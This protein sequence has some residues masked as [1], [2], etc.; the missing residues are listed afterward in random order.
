MLGQQCAKQTAPTGGSK[1]TIPPQLES[2][3]PKNKGINFKGTAIELTFDELVQLNN[4]REQIIITPSIG[5]KFEATVRK[6]KVTLE[7][8]SKLLEN[9]T[10]SINFR[11]SIQDLT[12]KNPAK[13]KIAFSTGSYIDSLSVTGFVTDILT[14]QRVKNYTVALVQVID[15]FNIFKHPA[16]WIGLTDDKGNFSIENL[17]PG[18][19]FLYAFNDAN[20]NLIVDGKSEKYGFKSDNINLTGTI[21]SVK[22][23]VVK[24]DIAALKLISARPTFAYFDMRL[25]KSLVDYKITSQT[26]SQELYSALQSDLTTI[27]VYNTLSDLDSLQVRLQA[28]DSIGSKVDSL[29]YVKFTKR[30]STKD[31]FSAIIESA[32]LDEQKAILTSELSFSKP[33]LNFNSD[34][35]YV[36]VDSVSRLTFTK[37]DFKWNT[38]LTKLTISKKLEPKPKPPVVP[39]GAPKKLDSE[40][41][42]NKIENLMILGKGSAISVEQDSSARTT[43]SLKI[44]VP[45]E[46]SVIQ[47]KVQTKEDF[48][49]QLL[50]RSYKVIQETKNGRAHV[51]ENINPGTYYMR[52]LIDLNKNGKWDGGNY[53]T[54]TQP[55][56]I[57]YYTNPKG[58]KDIFLKANWLVG[59]LL[60]SY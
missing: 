28:E 38:S 4:P 46:L 40:P 5:K 3:S 51:F 39:P 50:D 16:S 19:Y 56:P 18:N 21:D 59:D 31:K 60:I 10:Y 15:T 11:E 44:L 26:G 53:K 25:S 13:A 24:L 6:N 22:L 36:Q 34:S 20:K 48:I 27:K 14:D 32:Y 57:V 1:D 8:N 23:S 43:R 35:V 41:S 42:K 55:E 33:I 30:E 45:E 2:S 54:R 58:G 29:V 49:L 7:L 47:S 52:V 37:S 12:E 9:T 17:K